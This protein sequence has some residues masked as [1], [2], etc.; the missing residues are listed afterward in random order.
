VDSGAPKKLSLLDATLLVMGGIIGVGVF[1]APHF[2]ATDVRE[3]LVFL[4]LWLFGGG[5]ALLA[6]FT[7]A[8]LGGTFP[9]AGGWFVYLREAFGPFPA[10]L[11]AWIVL[12]VVSTG[13]A[14]AVTSFLAEQLGVAFPGLVRVEP[15]AA[16]APARERLLAERS[17]SALVILAVTAV[18]LTGVKRTALV[19]NACMAIKLAAIATFVWIAFA[20]GSGPADPAELASAVAPAAPP[21]ASGA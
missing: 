3:P 19:Q 21:S 16:G 4:G 1:L 7:F 10:F 14:A 5:I 9:R 8:E 15:S 2:V 18:A 13:A 20:P 6:A 17:V 11:F 12:F